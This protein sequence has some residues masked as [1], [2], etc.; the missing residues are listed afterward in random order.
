[1]WITF[2]VR[3]RLFK[4]DCQAG[5][6]GKRQDLSQTRE[7]LWHPCLGTV[8]VVT[9]FSAASH[10]TAAMQQVLTESCKSRLIQMAYESQRQSLVQQACAR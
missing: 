10:P 9:P 8:G 1:V 4:S 2:T 3:K 5:K 7:P 6:Q